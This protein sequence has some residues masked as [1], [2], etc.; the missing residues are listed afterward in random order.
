MFRD[1]VISRL[2]GR[3][4]LARDQNERRINFLQRFCFVFI[5]ISAKAK[6][7]IGVRFYEKLAIT[8]PPTSG[9]ETSRRRNINPEM[10]QVEMYISFGR[11]VL[12][13]CN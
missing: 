7:V 11:I 10:L 4:R 9:L 6:T 13:E 3:C 12:I 5:L 8:A 1:Y 2:I